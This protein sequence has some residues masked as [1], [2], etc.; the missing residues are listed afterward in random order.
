MNCIALDVD[1]DGDMDLVVP[2]RRDEVFWYVNPGIEKVK[3]PWPRK[4]IS[5][6]RG[7]MFM[8]VADVNGDKIDDFVIASSGR[9]INVHNAPSPAATSALNIGNLIVDKLDEQMD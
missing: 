9:I 6:H 5:S 2:D 7:A 8:V 4:T 3:Q 1:K